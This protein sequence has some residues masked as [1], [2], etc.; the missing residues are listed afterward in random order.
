MLA[1]GQLMAQQSD[2]AKN[3]PIFVTSG[4][5]ITPTAAPGSNL[6]YLNPGLTDFPKYIA[7]GGISTAISPDGNTL[8][9]LT[10]GYNNLDDSS[11]SF[12]AADSQEYIFVFDISKGNPTQKQVLTLPNSYTGIA[13]EPSGQTFLAA[14][15]VDDNV[16]IFQLQPSGQWADT[17]SPVALGHKHG[18]GLVSDGLALTASQDPPLAGGVAIVPN[19]SVNALV[20]NVYND[21]VSLIGISGNTG[22][23]LAELDLRP[24]KVNSHDSGVPGGEY[25]FWV[26]VTKSGVAYISS[27]R[28]REVDVVQVSSSQL[29]FVTR[30]KV[31]GNPNK[32]ILDANEANL[33]VAEDNSDQVDVISTSTNQVVNSISTVG[34]KDVIGSLATYHGFIPN[35]LTLSADGK[36]LYVT[37]AGTNS[38]AIVD[39]TKTPN[40][41]VGLI[42]TGYYPNDVSVSKDGKTLYVVNAKSVTGP[43]PDYFPKNTPAENASNQYIEKD[44]KSSLLS[45]PVPASATL[46]KLTRQVA[47]NNNFGNG[48]PSKDEAIFK[49][50]HKRIKHVIYIIKENRTYDQVLGDLDRGNGDPYITEFGAA[51]T[52]SQH[53]LATNFVDADNF[54]CSGDVSANGW[55]WSTSGRE[56]DLGTKS[57]PL[58]YGTNPGSKGGSRGTDYEYEGDNRELNVGIGNLTDRITADPATPTDPDIL[59]GTGNVAAPDGPG[60]TNTQAGYIWDAVQR[61]NLL[62]RDY[63]MFIDL[64]RYSAP[65]GITGISIPED[66]DPYSSGTQVA[67]VT[68]P[69]L[70]Q[71]FD[72]Y[73]RGFDNVFPDFYRETE[74]EREFDGY[75]A[76]GGLPSLE[77]VR[78]MHDHTGNFTT[79]LD[80]VNTVELQQADNDYAVGALI[81]RLASSQYKDDTLVFV[82]EDDAQDGADHVDAHRSIFFVAGPYVK[83]GAV[84]SKPYTTV[85]L[86]RTI[87]DILGIDH[88]NVHTATATPMTELFDLGQKNWDFKAIAS[89]YLKNT[90]LPIP[91]GAYASKSIPRPTHDA[92]YWADKT[93]GFDFSVEDHLGNVEKFNRIV[94]EGLKGSAPYPAQRTG[95]DLRQNRKQL[96]LRTA[97]AANAGS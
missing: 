20:T 61:A 3:K 19:T 58:N 2:T 8:L 36:T 39:L 82:L 26:T 75:D 53:A 57:V 23:V 25:P 63:G 17:G 41:V 48:S 67:W 28:D 81:Q 21:S 10:A 31:N 52:P 88:L 93:R 50:L 94:W 72:P 79:A 9:V 42:P 34:P 33:Y 11:G 55:P 38:L 80:G 78:F 29:A 13:F 47:Q 95:I 51:Y 62:V 73:F 91:S 16:H 60:T 22:Q 6:L 24:G 92:S 35:G 43:D 59:P 66:T 84:V 97:T 68:M 56:S 77:L 90:T 18:I 1:C 89:D 64:T 14:G 4:Q 40:A 74:W 32:M 54:Y 86:L 76:N 87:E 83:H 49:E 46:A 70:Q 27:V 15:G 65:Q 71:Y 45:F 12:I 5:E 7:S 37:N 69:E 85:N 44:E 96:L 30:I